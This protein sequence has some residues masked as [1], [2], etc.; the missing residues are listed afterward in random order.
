KLALSIPPG[1][2]PGISWTDWLMLQ[3]ISDLRSATDTSR[4]LIHGIQTRMLYKRIATFAR[5]GPYEDIIRAL[6]ELDWP[7]RADLCAKLHN[8]VHDKL[9]RDWRSLDTAT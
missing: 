5:G 6:E 1:W 4:S 8:E 9:R 3:W 7:D 2:Y